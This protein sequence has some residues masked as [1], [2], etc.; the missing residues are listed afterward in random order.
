MQSLRPLCNTSL[1]ADAIHCVEVK[2][3]GEWNKTSSCSMCAIFGVSVSDGRKHDY[4]SLR[5]FPLQFVPEGAEIL[6]A[7]KDIY[8]L[9]VRA[10]HNMRI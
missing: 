3:I 1:N 9:V 4:R 8:A 2:E 10:T 5:V 6:I 7:Q